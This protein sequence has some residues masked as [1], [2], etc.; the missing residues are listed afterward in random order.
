MF[1]H[2]NDPSVKKVS[3]D[4]ALSA[5]E[6]LDAVREEA[7]LA[8]E[9]TDTRIEPSLGDFDSLLSNAFAA[10]ADKEIKPDEGVSDVM[11]EDD[12]LDAALF[13]DEVAPING[14][15][16]D[17][18][19]SASADEAIISASEEEATKASLMEELG[20]TFGDP[21]SPAQGSAPSVGDAMPPAAHTFN[22]GINA[23]LNA[24]QRQQGAD[25]LES[26][27]RANAPGAAGDLSAQRHEVG[28]IQGMSMLG[29]AGLAG[30]TKMLRA[31]GSQINNSINTRKYGKLSGEVD[32]ISQ[33]MDGILNKFG[34][35]GFTAGL[36][37]LKGENRAEFV[38]DF[39]AN[40]ANKQMFDDLVQSVGTLSTKATQAVVAG[41]A[42]GLSGDQ[43]DVE[44]SRKI[45]NVSDKHKEML[46]SLHDHNGTKLSERLSEMVDTIA[47]FLKSVFI[48]VAES[49][50]YNQRSDRPG[51]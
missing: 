41:A 26:I 2:D 5:D 14:S 12:L 25:T 22:E 37:G 23:S 33:N 9:E 17:A 49:L 30:L 28:I 18:K 32:T 10:A 4:T 19:S 35:S 11:T 16:S 13:D 36:K 15:T 3:F 46:D 45:K 39:M 38:K 6:E 51:M 43:L 50:G 44:I 31:G 29:G 40:P 8:R 34:A 48:K 7:S 27:A 1:A 20:E 42:A 24:A 21:N 47:D